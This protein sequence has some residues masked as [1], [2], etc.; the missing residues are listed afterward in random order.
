MTVWIHSCMLVK[1][2]QNTVKQVGKFL[3]I[4]LGTLDETIIHYYGRSVI[5]GLQSKAITNI[6]SI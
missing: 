4:I 1:F 3:F 2:R 5:S 6:A